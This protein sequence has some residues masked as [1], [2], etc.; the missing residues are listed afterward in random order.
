[1]APPQEIQK[2]VSFDVLRPEIEAEIT[3]NAVEMVRAMI[4]HAKEGQS[5]AMKYLFEMIGLYPAKSDA[6]GPRNESPGGLL[7]LLTLPAN[8]TAE[9]VEDEQIPVSAPANAVE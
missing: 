1:M 7:S 4:Q 8:K 6:E 3:S 2:A 9:Q 5:Q